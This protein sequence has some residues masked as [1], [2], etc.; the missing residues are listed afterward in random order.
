[1]FK[2]FVHEFKSKAN[3]LPPEITHFL[4]KLVELGH[5]DLC[6]HFLMDRWLARILCNQLA[7]KGF[8]DVPLDN[9]VL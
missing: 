7:D 1:M 5:K 9:Q 4:C 3:L 6:R 2:T 8:L